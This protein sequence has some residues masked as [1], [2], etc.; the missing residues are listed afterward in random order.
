MKWNKQKMDQW[1]CHSEFKRHMNMWL[2]E[3]GY[4]VWVFF[5]FLLSFLHECSPSLSSLY[6]NFFLILCFWMREHIVARLCSQLLTLSLTGAELVQAK[7][8]TL[9][10]A[11]RWKNYASNQSCQIRWSQRESLVKEARL[12]HLCDGVVLCGGDQGA[13][14]QGASY[15]G[16]S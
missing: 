8:S 11:V 13:V 12:K 2:I 10:S 1:H 15:S 3:T 9:P 14:E 6:A 7:S 16:Y 4:C 5:L